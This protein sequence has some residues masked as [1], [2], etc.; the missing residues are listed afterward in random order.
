MRGGSLPAP[1]LRLLSVEISAMLALVERFA[2]DPARELPPR[3][4]E[5]GQR[6]AAVE[7]KGVGGAHRLGAP[8]VDGYPHCASASGKARSESLSEG[9]AEAAAAAGGGTSAHTSGSDRWKV[10]P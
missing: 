2:A 9:G 7:P 1:L 5:L 4:A 6:K 8:S 10:D 3:D